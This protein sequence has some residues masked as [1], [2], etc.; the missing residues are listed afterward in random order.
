MEEMVKGR[1]QWCRSSGFADRSP[2]IV[3]PVVMEN[4]EVRK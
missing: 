2:N 3:L 4:E 1:R